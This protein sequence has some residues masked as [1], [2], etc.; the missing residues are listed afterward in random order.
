[1]TAVWLAVALSAATAALAAGPVVGVAAA[2]RLGGG[3]D[4]AGTPAASRWAIHAAAAGV[5]W[6]LA[7]PA[8]LLVAPVAVLGGRSA[9]RTHSRRAEAA[10]CRSAVPAACRALAAELAAGSSPADAL[11]AVARGAPG[12]LQAALLGAAAAAPLGLDPAVVLGGDDRPGCERLRLVAACWRVCVAS[13]G[14][15]ADALTRLADGL[16]D[17][18]DAA[19]EIAAQLV[20]PR[21]SALV[22]A[23]LPLVGVLLGASLGARPLDF[24]TST[25]LGLGCLLT[26]VLLDALGLLWVASIARRAAA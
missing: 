16:A 9:V 25:P 7:G 14:G 13:G 21:M 10:V 19:A 3:H 4:R 6:W 1:M 8:G 24:L 2:G 12:P 20:G 23:A 15:L 17:E 18:Q 26:G 11:S 22:M 5:G